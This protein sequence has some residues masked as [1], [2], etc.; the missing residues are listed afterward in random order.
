[1]S[2][3]RVSCWVERSGSGVSQGQ[4]KA[5]THA[6]P[7]PTAEEDC[8]KNDLHPFTHSLRLRQTDSCLTCQTCTHTHW[9]IPVWKTHTHTFAC[10]DKR[11]LDSPAGGSSHRSLLGIKRLNEQEEDVRTGSPPQLFFLLF[12]IHVSSR[13]DEVGLLVFGVQVTSCPGCEEEAGLHGSSRSAAC[14]RLFL[15][16][17]HL[18][19]SIHPGADQL[20]S[21]PGSVMVSKIPQ[22]DR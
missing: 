18:M 4:G 15:A 12:Y 2:L 17:L 1:M 19:A 20:L 9:L 21:E 3:G 22:T 16:R 7:A 10:F 5:P 14:P 11:W 6:E 13:L 8:V